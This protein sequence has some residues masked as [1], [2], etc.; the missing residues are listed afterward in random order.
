MFSTDKPID[1]LEKDLLGRKGFSKQLAEAIA[2]FDSNDNLTIGLYGSWGS[3]KT[4]VLNMALQHLETI[5]QDNSDVSFTV[6][7]FNPWNFTD[8]NQLLN[9]F[10]KVLYSDLNIHNSNSN[11]K[12]IGEA[13]EK[14]A[15]ALEYS[16][17][18]PTVGKY[19]KFLPEFAKGIG[20]RIKN[21]ADGKL[22]DALF[23]KAAVEKVLREYNGKILIVIDDI[24]RLTNEQIRLVF[25]LVSSV[26]GF[27]N[28]IYLLSFDKAI[29][30]HALEEVQSCDGMDY[31]EK[32]IQVPFELPEVSSSKIIDILLSELQS[33][34]QDVPD[35]LF[36][37]KHWQKVFISCIKPFIGNI[38]DIRR[39]IN[40][41]RF[42]VNPIKDEVDFIDLAG[43]TSLQIFAP[44][45][46]EWIFQNRAELIGGV[47]MYE[48]ITPAEQKK[49]KEQYD[50]QF[51]SVYPQSPGIMNSAVAALFPRFARKVQFNYE[52]LTDNDL[53]RFM[54]IAHGDKFDRYFSLSTDD[55]SISRALLNSTLYDMDKPAIEEMLIEII[56]NG[57]LRDYIIELASNQ[58]SIPLNR[59]SLFIDILFNL[60]PCTPIDDG[61]LVS[62][63]YTCGSIIWDLLF[64]ISNEQERL[65][66]MVDLI[67][68]ASEDSLSSFA[69]LLNRMELAQGRLAA[70]GKQRESA[71]FSVESITELEKV[72]VSRLHN[73]ISETPLLDWNYYLIPAY[74]WSCFD[75][76]GYS[77]YMRTQFENPICI[78]KY[79]SNVARKWTSSDSNI[80]WSFK[81]SEDFNSIITIDEAITAINQA[82]ADKT[83]FSFN[84]IDQLKI[85]SFILY[86]QGTK[87]K[88]DSI[89]QK[90]AKELIEKLKQE[91]QV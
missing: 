60:M 10:F 76:E 34:F 50:L 4:S 22:N 25:Q 75:K 9:Q 18:I 55:I 26:A 70:Q 56:R 85:A 6:I 79:V 89:S 7:R 65:E 2:E 45:I 63:S 90:D 61:F 8:C 62:A 74:L 77:Q 64:R 1:K 21:D 41:L 33:L 78:L 31:L 37:K 52:Y 39:Y 44:P 80:G 47:S 29:V 30:A 83:L 51:Q 13:I 36:D 48:G 67:S 59:V 14:Y 91:T 38:R 17:Y 88:L 84:E 69:I 82:V 66:I 49:A 86:S 46:Y 73:L 71:P 53:R 87:S 57:L 81:E 3:G 20:V 32:I 19:L 24:D 42:E 35:N 58:I 54:R 72:F 27:P 68:G 11:K 15:S 43:I 16:E 5:L 23:Q 28:V 12:K 40:V